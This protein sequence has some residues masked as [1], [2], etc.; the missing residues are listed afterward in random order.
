M[1]A[2]D[3]AWAITIGLLVAG[4]IAAVAGLAVA[5][6]VLWRRPRTWWRVTLFCFVLLF[7][8]GGLVSLGQI[9][10]EVF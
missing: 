8:F 1:N 5:A 9:A 4:L 3:I 7:A 6:W 10:A 2:Q